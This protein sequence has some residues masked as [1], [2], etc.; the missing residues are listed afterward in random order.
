MMDFLD[1]MQIEFLSPL[2][3]TISEYMKEYDLLI[4]SIE[5]DPADYSFYKACDLY[6]GWRSRRV[7]SKSR[8]HL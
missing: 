8:I 6:A 4:V 7:R 5:G 1:C 3:L 2:Y